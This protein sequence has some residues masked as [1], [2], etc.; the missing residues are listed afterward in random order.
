MLSLLIGRRTIATGSYRNNGGFPPIVHMLP[1]HLS[2]THNM[3]LITEP[4]DLG[5]IFSKTV[6]VIGKSIGKTTIVSAIIIIPLF[7]IIALVFSTLIGDM[8]TAVQSSASNGGQMSE[9]TGREFARS[10]F[11]MLPI[12]FLLIGLITLGYCA[13]EAAIIRLYCSTVEERPMTWRESFEGVF[14]GTM[15]RLLAQRIL[16]TIMLLITYIPM[17]F[18]MFIPLLGSLGVLLG[19][20]CVYT[21]FWFA[22]VAIVNE[23]AGIIESFRRGYGLVKERFWRVL[24]IGLLMYVISVIIIYIIAFVLGLAVMSGSGVAITD[25]AANMN[26]LDPAEK[27]RQISAALAAAAPGLVFVYGVLFII[28]LIMQPSFQVV[29][30][31]DERIWNREWPEN[32]NEVTDDDFLLS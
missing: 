18:L 1:S 24:G 29:M 28:L 26:S 19:Y 27:S 23:D 7:I 17:I 12:F 32:E 22:P 6:K 9:E 30:Y 3:A 20:A 16:L 11:G 5:D 8:A 2:T 25:L 10:M 14:S 15:W 13:A 4:L 21:A 31:Y